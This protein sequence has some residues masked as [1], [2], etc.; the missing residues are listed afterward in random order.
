VAEQT[1]PMKTKLESLVEKK[2]LGGCW[3]REKR[4][5][6]KTGGPFLFAQRKILSKKEAPK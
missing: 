5:P 4:I 3:E 6:K 2:D 1:T